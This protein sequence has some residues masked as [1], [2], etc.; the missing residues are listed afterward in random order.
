MAN[1]VPDI[2][3]ISEKK[4]N[5]FRAYLEASGIFD[6][7]VRGKKAVLT[8]HRMQTPTRKAKVNVSW[9]YS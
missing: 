4:K 1:V 9:L 2:A 8:G 6:V 7:L 5:S 3:A